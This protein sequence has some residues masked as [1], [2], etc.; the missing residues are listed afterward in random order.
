MYENKL[1]LF[2]L[3]SLWYVIMATLA[4]SLEM[5]GWMNHKQESGFLGQI[6]AT[7]DMQM[8]PL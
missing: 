5:P 4:P 1:L 3:P 7:S 6:S 8:I 2:K